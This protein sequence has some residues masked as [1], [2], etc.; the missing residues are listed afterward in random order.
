VGYA[1][2]HNWRKCTVKRVNF[3]YFTYCSLKHVC[4]FIDS[5]RLLWQEGYWNGIKFSVFQS[6]VNADNMLYI[7]VNYQGALT[8][9]FG[10]IRSHSMSSLLFYTNITFNR[11]VVCVMFSLFPFKVWPCFLQSLSPCFQP[12]VGQLQYFYIERMQLFLWQWCSHWSMISA[13]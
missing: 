5:L 11:I 8:F 2:Q 10:W 7:S 12:C 9:F 1:E 3:V 6:A 4:P 13:Y